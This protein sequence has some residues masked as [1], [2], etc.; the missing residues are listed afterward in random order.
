ML[1]QKITFVFTMLLFFLST[2]GVSLYVHRCSSAGGQ[3][4]TAYPELFGVQ[5]GCCTF[6]LNSPSP[7]CHNEGPV[8]KSL[9][10][11]GCCTVSLYYGRL[12]TD[13]LPQE[14]PCHTILPMEHD[15]LPGEPFQRVPQEE[16]LSCNRF[17]LFRP[18]PASCGHR[19]QLLGQLRISPD[20]L[21]A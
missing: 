13:F 20:P 15:V 9:R 1:L 3:D 10:G 17:T 6:D 7:C 12:S 16:I 4:F 19:L 14:G 5:P 8:H 2:A 21:P 18:P 11:E